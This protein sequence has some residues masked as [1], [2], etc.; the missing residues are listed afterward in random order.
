MNNTFLVTIAV[1]FALIPVSQAAKNNTSNQAAPTRPVDRGMYLNNQ[2]I[3]KIYSSMK[4]YIKKARASYPEAKKKWEQAL[5]KGQYFFVVTR[6][7]DQHG[8]EEQVFISVNEIKHG[9]IKGYIFNKLN[10]VSGY[11]F[12]QAYSFPESELIDWV[13]TKP[14]GEQEGNFVGKYLSSLR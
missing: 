11:E 8:V 14:N 12:K 9:I 2:Q 1:F 3:K 6:I 5:P 7:R 13:I 4:P 10:N